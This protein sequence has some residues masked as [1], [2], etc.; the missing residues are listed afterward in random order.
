MESYRSVQLELLLE[1]DRLCRAHDIPYILSRHT[2]RAAW[3]DGTLPGSIA[4]PTIAMRCSDAL[5]LSQL[6]D[7]GTR[8]WESSLDNRNIPRTVMRYS[9]PETLLF[10]VDEADQYKHHG[11]CV[12][13][14]LIRDV[15]ANRLLHRLLVVAEAGC[16]SLCGARSASPLWKALLTI[17]KPLEKAILRVAYSGKLPASGQVRIVRFP[18][19]N[20][21]FPAAYLTKRQEV[22]VEGHPFFL[23]EAGERYLLAEYDEKWR[24]PTV[25]GPDE[26]LHVTLMDAHVSCQDAADLIHDAL[27][28]KPRVPL[29]RRTLLLA[30]NRKLRLKIE[31][32]WAILF[33]TKDRFDF[34]RQLMPRKE[35][36]LSLHRQGNLDELKA[37]LKPYL[38]AI[39]KHYAKGLVLCFDQDILNIAL[40]LLE[41]EGKAALAQKL[42]ADVFPEH[43]KPMKIEGYDHE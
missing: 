38:A 21:E 31:R 43:L 14:E 2:A 19:K 36:L 35:E 40:A 15:P 29:L 6:T 39:N 20:L 28:E 30:R 32:N 34:H 3:L 33:L 26:D 37:I 10:R 42:R 4:V 18:K 17:F 22:L 11:L 41:K 5:R 7:P 9:N 13:V 23:P 8:Q 25:L 1:L 27:Q 16:A 24:R 12:D